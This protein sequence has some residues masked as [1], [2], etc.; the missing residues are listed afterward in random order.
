MKKLCLFLFLLFAANVNAQLR[1]DSIGQV[2]VK[3]ST[4]LPNIMLGVG[5][6][7]ANAF[8]SMNLGIHS[9]VYSDKI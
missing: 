8:T 3:R 9:Y 4:N 1:V 7:Y 2:S 5:P 6:Q